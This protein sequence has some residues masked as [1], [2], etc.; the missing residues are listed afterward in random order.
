MQANPSAVDVVI[1]D[2]KMPEVDGLSL[3]EYV[4]T[5]LPSIIV[6]IISGFGEFEYARRA[7]QYNV[8]DYLLKPLKDQQLREL[9]AT[10]AVR[11][12]ESK[13]TSRF[14]SAKTASTG[15]KKKELVRAIL[16]EDAASIYQAYEAIEQ[17]EG[18]AMRAFG[19]IARC[20]P[21]YK[22]LDAG[23]EHDVES[24]FYSLNILVNALCAA[25]DCVCLYAKNGNTYV[26]IDGDS[27]ADLQAR[28]QT[29]HRR[30]EAKSEHPFDLCC[31]A[32]VSDVML[33]PQSMKSLAELQR[34]APCIDSTLLYDVAIQHKKD[35]LREITGALRQI[36]ADIDA[37]NREALSVDN[38]FFCEHYLALSP[39]C[40]WRA[41][42]LLIDQVAST[43]QLDAE[44]RAAAYQALSNA[45]LSHRGS[46]GSISQYA[47]SLYQSA[48]ALLRPE[49][50]ASVQELPVIHRAREYILEN[51][52]K[53]I[54]LLDVAAYC[55]V[56]SN[57]LSG[58]FQK[59]VGA[60][61]SKYLL[62]LRM[63]QAAKLLK[64]Y[65]DM[66]IYEAAEHSGFTSAKHFIA[67]FKKHYGVS[68][69]IFQKNTKND[70]H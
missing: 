13:G 54:S 51:Y 44:Q 5:H 37:G 59:Q 29:L 17:Q 10:V 62:Q 25:M 65:P 38:R 28:V 8:T 21:L 50:K 41:G 7:I 39:I 18:R 64:N 69:Q 56:S 67:V 45:C 23:S 35:T 19:C 9:L 12:S 47:A 36:A 3:A 22:A 6:I 2:I 20:R 57:Y 27:P 42:A 63:E 55:G 30:I 32:V 26:L 68:P 70:S 33:L 66:K 11:L 60:S 52:Q 4:R 49:G 53:N 31:G 40:L 34:L 58:I 61:Y 14:R 43:R 24:A 16:D 1:T 46:H 15:G 48:A